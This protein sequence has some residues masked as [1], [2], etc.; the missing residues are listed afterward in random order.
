M[1]AIIAG[2]MPDK[3]P[4]KTEMARPVRIFFMLKIISR[5]PAGISV[6][7]I[8]SKMPIPPPI[9]LRKIAS[10]RNWKRIKKFFAPSDF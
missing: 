9:R 5:E 1:E 10:K 3:S 4:I 7:S 6:I 2:I 8:T